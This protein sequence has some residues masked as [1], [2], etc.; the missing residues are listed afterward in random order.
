MSSREIRDLSPETQKKYNKFYDAV[1]RDIGLVKHGVTV[2]LTCTYRSEEEQAKL[3]GL[4]L[5]PVKACACEHSATTPQG[6][7]AST[8]FDV[9]ML[10]YGKVVPCE[11]MFWDG[12]IE[13]AKNAGLTKGCEGFHG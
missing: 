13:H 3:F 2:L 10:R 11:G 9:V 12:I 8:S 1:R 5:T 7:P 6:M 4:G